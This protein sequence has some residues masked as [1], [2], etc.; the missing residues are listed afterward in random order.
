MCSWDEAMT[1]WSPVRRSVLVVFVLSSL[2]AC[3]E[4]QLR[5]QSEGLVLC[6]EKTKRIFLGDQHTFHRMKMIRDRSSKPPMMLPIRI[7]SEMGMA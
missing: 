2:L 4:S 5:K 6:L 1:L 3:E 7:Q